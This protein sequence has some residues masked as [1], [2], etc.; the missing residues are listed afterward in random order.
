[1][2]LLS[3]S[4]KSFAS[5]ILL[6]LTIG[7]ATTKS[8]IPNVEPITLAEMRASC[9]PAYNQYI[10]VNDTRFSVIL[11]ED[12]LG[13]ENILI[14]I[15]LDEISDEI[16]EKARFAAQMF[17]LTYNAD[18]NSSYTHRYL[19]TDKDVINTQGN[20]RDEAIVYMHVYLLENTEE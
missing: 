18:T 12:C 10:H 1:M 19:N 5:I 20:N 14:V 17:V 13:H 3:K 7:C 15:W 16:I 4:F 2:L 9:R 8:A 6:L 11:A